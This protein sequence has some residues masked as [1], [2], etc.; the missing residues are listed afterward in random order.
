LRRPRL[1]WQ[2]YVPLLAVVSLALLLVSAL[3]VRSLRDLYLETTSANLEA[4]A[5]LTAR[6]LADH[7]ALEFP[8]RLDAEVKKLGALTK[9]RI[10]VVLASGGVVAESS[11]DADMMDNHASR[12]EIKGALQGAITR[13]VRFSN[14]VREQLTYVAVPLYQEGRVVA[15]VRTAVPLTAIEGALRAV[16]LRTLAGGIAIL[17]LA[18]AVIFFVSREISSPFEEIEKA[19]ASFAAGRLDV[20][21]PVSGSGEMA[22]V[23]TAMNR[24]AAELDE[25]L[26]TVV[27]QRNEQEAVLSS[28]VEGVI[29]IDVDERV[30][31]INEAAAHL[32]DLDPVA[33]IGRPVQEVARNPELQRFA[34]DALAS[35]TAIEGDLTLHGPELCYLQAHGAPIRDGRHRRIGSVLVLNDVTRQRRLETVRS[36]FVANVSH[37]LKTPITSI[38]GFL[39]TLADGAV[40]DP[41]N[42]RRFLA[43]ALRQA[44]RL[45][46]IIED[47]LSLSRVE[48]EAESGELPRAFER[49]RDILQGAVDV[50]QSKA[51]AKG[52]AVN[53]DCPEELRA[54]VNAP[55]LEQALVNLID[56]AVKYSDPGST[57]DVEAVANDANVTI[58]VRDRGAGIEATHLPRVFERFYRVDKARSRT[59]GGTGLGLSIVKHIAA[60]HGGTVEVESEP[61]K[62][63][64]FTLTLPRGDSHKSNETAMSA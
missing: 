57:V 5:Q 26:R 6:L 12:P 28:M 48:Q 53:L 42:A 61:G 11:A 9:T 58:K 54:D 50:C 2:L 25:R 62:G 14:T 40:D 30:I 44:D 10:T 59:L 56:N 33:C 43:I 60:A 49:V 39:E 46:A 51:D 13:S 32:L 63:T 55:L 24:M 29:A 22:S 38:K 20:R 8:E 21:V 36:D 41:Q 37:E 7:G 1:V 47:L 23:A 27:R 19:A 18:A 15:A 17:V 3:S 52:I 35:E 64:V 4:Q 16:N 45:N 34:S 31:S